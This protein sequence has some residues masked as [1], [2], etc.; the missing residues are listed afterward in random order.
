MD[1]LFSLDLALLHF[2]NGT[3]ASL[4]LDGFFKVI[5]DFG[6]FQIPLLILFIWM[7]LRISWQRRYLLV[8]MLLCVGFADL[9]GNNGKIVIGRDR[10]FHT[11]EVRQ[12]EGLRYSSRS[13]S[14]P[15][16][17][18]ANNFAMAGFLIFA[19]GR[20]LP[21]VWMLLLPA[22]LVA[23]SRVYLGVHYPSD[24]VAG[25]L[26]GL[27][28]AGCVA[29]ANRARPA[30]KFSAEGNPIGVDWLGVTLLVM[31]LAVLHLLA[32]VIR[33]E[34]PL[35]PEE[36]QYW[37]WSRHLDWSYYSKPP[38][39]AYLIYAST[40]V[41]GSN[42][43]G[44]RMTAALLG[45]GTG[46]IG[47]F[48]ARRMYE[49]HRIAF[50]YVLAL[51][52]MPL[53]AVGSVIITTDAPLMF[54]WAACIGF[55]YLALVEERPWAWY[56]AGAAAAMGLLSK[57]A[58]IYVFPCLVFFL[59]WDPPSR[60]FWKT[61]HPYAFLVVALAGF[62]PVIYWNM[63]NDWV[64]FR[65]VATQTTGESEG[66]PINPG[67][68]FA[69]IGEQAALV[70]PILFVFMM[71]ASWRILRGPAVADRRDAFLMWFGLPVFLGLLLRSATD[72]VL[73]NWAAPAYFTLTLL[74]VR[75]MDKMFA[76]GTLSRKKTAWLAGGALVYGGLFLVLA[77]EPSVF[78]D[79]AESLR[80]IGIPV[81]AKADP[82]YQ[83]VGFD[84]LGERVTEVLQEFD[85]PQR[86]FLFTKRYQAAAQMAFY[87]EGQPRTYTINF[88]E[89]RMTQYDIWGG[90]EDGHKGWDAIYVTPGDGDELEARIAG[91]FDS[92][93]DPEYVIAEV[94]D[95]EYRRFT[96]YRLRN[97]DGEFEEAITEFTEF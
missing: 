20:S 47:Y 86:V 53:F 12:V 93:S 33:Q 61:L 42:A 8:L 80:K 62:L 87:V 26:L 35:A 59:L 75:W 3:M 66:F 43:I 48:L 79:A 39:I 38:A 15:S 14:F 52:L 73:G 49:N 51:F 5:S 55:L 76:E 25:A 50:F 65:H 83:M 9:A 1:F 36:A 40:A 71:L 68:F 6:L 17:H 92:C 58:M 11:V 82:T 78:R 84:E 19:V 60:R 37:D 31:P 28:V 41:F 67:T 64:G 4:Y 30:V 7:M 32:V 77:K 10:P 81:P 72:D 85:D 44:V 34:V 74:A 21:W 56:A 89:R 27:G 24:V 2:I 97:F 57:Y 29:A 13:G 90:L 45:I 88:G 23:V 54:F 91:N 46:L 70:N 96:I 63:T 16:N 94:D 22:S 95:V 18:A 69:Y